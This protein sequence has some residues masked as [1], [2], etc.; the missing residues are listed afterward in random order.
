MRFKKILEIN[1]LYRLQDR[2]GA[3]GF[4]T[5]YSAMHI[6]SQMPCA[7]KII[8]KA[9]LHT[10]R[11]RTL[12][13]NEFEILEQISHPHITRVYELLE[14]GF[15]FYIV[16][17]LMK[18]GSLERRIR[19]DRF[20]NSLTSEKIARIIYQVLLALN[21]CHNIHIIHRDIKP[22]NVLCEDFTDL[23]RD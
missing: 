12:N 19:D 20:Y 23:S 13:Q 5:V 8:K 4:G 10:S 9:D 6:D 18:G 17:E 15:N 16:M 11:L 7:I 14:D 21:F 3:G 1:R 22:D 2:L